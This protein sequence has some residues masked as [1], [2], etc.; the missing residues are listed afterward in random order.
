MKKLPYDEIE[1]LVYA[2][3]KGSKDAIETLLKHY[4]QYF[5]KFLQVL[6][7]TYTVI[8]RDGR[9]NVR[10]SKFDIYNSIQR[11]FATA[12][13]KSKEDRN[14]IRLYRKNSTVCVKVY[15][16][17]QHIRHLFA[18]HDAD[19][20]LQTMR[21]IFIQ[22]AKRHKGKKFYNYISTTFPKQLFSHLIRSLDRFDFV[23]LDEEWLIV[24]YNY[25]HEDEYRLEGPPLKY[26]V[27]SNEYTMYDVNWLNGD[28][29]EIFDCLTP[30]ERKILKWYYEYKT[31]F[32]EDFMPEARDIFE[33]RRY[34]L[35]RTDSDIAEIL[36]CSR[37]TVNEK[38]RHIISVLEEI[39][40]EK[41]LI[42]E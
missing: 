20:L 12:F 42:K 19:D 28:C 37:K 15:K 13:M 29:G 4:E 17:V 14:S 3:Q 36:G 16:T 11:R 41:R 31:F 1:V 35:K 10:H 38:R 9:K 23:P 7:P 18:R 6:K 40:R 22:M 24:K 2:Y 8:G 21:L 30:H 25:Y 5:L 32:D 34:R 26:Y 33:E 27:N 39:L